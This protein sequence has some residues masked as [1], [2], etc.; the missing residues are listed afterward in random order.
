MVIMWP[1]LIIYN[2]ILGEEKADAMYKSGMVVDMI[3]IPQNKKVN[4]SSSYY[5]SH[6]QAM[7]TPV[8]EQVA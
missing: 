3:Y 6:F 2:C 4:M 5:L 7:N 8:M 1:L